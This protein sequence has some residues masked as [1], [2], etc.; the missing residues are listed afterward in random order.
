L[1]EWSLAADSINYL[2]AELRRCRPKRVLEFGSGVSTVV[3]AAIMRSLAPPFSRPSVI[4]I[5]QDSQ[6]IVR[7]NR[8][9]RS[10]S[11]ES[12]VR[13]VHQPLVLCRVYDASI[14]CYGL[15]PAHLAAAF[16]DGKADFIL[17]D[18]PVG[19]SGCR[20]ATLPRVLGVVSSGAR[21][22]MDDALR[23]GELGVA[24]AWT[25]DPRISVSGIVFVG[26]G[27]L[28]GNVK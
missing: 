22:L 6:E 14:L 25:K 8:L 11:L 21:F 27:F 23:D 16:A 24:R 5:E 26:K 4:S 10:A 20:V 1:G 28:V 13:L 3:L 2:E 9:L 12:D 18:G 19:P 17:I 15:E 7:T